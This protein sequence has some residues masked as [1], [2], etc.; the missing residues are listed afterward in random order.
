MAGVRP[1]RAGEA[2]S[3]TA[4]CLRSKAHWG[5]DA[6]FMRL[7]VPSLTVKE[8]SIA[9]GRVL[10]AI[11]ADGRTIGTVSVGRDGDDAELALMFVDPAA[12]GGGT[13]R[14]LFEA[15]VTLAR[16]LGY[17]RMTILADVNA[18]PFYE[19]MGARFLRNEPSDAIP[20]RVLPF[21]EYDLTAGV[22]P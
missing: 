12:I 21:Y 2:A 16:G 9:E 7:C 13:G 1:A 8:E 19:R 4:L 3:L 15:A 5:Y 10:V 6:G 14:T 11:D 20:G 22:E 18:A 17:R